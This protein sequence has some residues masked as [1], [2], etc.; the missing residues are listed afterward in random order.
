MIEV[1]L[2]DAPPFPNQESEPSA[3]QEG[4]EEEE[5]EVEGDAEK[6]AKPKKKE[7]KKAMR[8]CSFHSVASRWL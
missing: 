5:A 7:E 4:K 8:M 3:M 2:L 6:E 1:F